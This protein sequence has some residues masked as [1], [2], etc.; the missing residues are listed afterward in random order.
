MQT[1]TKSHRP[2]RLIAV[3]LSLGVAV[4]LGASADGYGRAYAA[5]S[6]RTPFQCQKQFHTSEG[7][8]RCFAQLPGADCDHPLIAEK[9]GDTTRGEHQ[10]FRLSYHGEGPG[11]GSVEESYSYRPASPN[12]A[13]CPHGVVF[14]VSLLR[15]EN[16]CEL[17]HHDGHAEEYCSVEY[18]TKSIPEPSSPRG[19]SFSYYLT[20]EPR[21]TA[22]LEIKG[23][24]IHPPWAGR[25]K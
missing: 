13:I 11:D 5:K 18:D 24:F 9:A 23:Y 7:R 6:P 19:G 2:L 25:S 10:Y 20:G 15:D 3:V 17:R 16:H 8:A 4:G 21:K 12:V 22:Y 1:Q 14:K